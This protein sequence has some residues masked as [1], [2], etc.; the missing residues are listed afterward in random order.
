MTAEEFWW[1]CGLILDN[2]P[3]RIRSRRPAFVGGLADT[4]FSL[5]G[6]AM[7]AGQDVAGFQFE[8][9]GLKWHGA[10]VIQI[11]FTHGK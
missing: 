1:D 3:P 10:V 9:E 8:I 6:L 5:G 4:G 2:Y 11:L 7:F